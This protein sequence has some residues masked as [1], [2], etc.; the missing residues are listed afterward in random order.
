MEVRSD[1]PHTQALFL[2]ITI[3][4]EKQTTKLVQRKR[5]DMSNVLEPQHEL[6]CREATRHEETQTWDESNKS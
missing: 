6:R 4:P 1:L 3:S 2:Y 5:N